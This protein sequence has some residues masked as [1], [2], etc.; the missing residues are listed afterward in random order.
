[1]ADIEITGKK[2]M[3]YTD[4][5]KKTD[6]PDIEVEQIQNYA[7]ELKGKALEV[8]LAEVDD[9]ELVNEIHRRMIDRNN[10]IKNIARC[11]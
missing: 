3:N 7:K 2:F 8:F 5:R 11:L 10:R 4:L 9:I 1:M 6:L